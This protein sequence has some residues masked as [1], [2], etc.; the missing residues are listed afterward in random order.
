LSIASNPTAPMMLKKISTSNSLLAMPRAV[1]AAGG[2]SVLVIAMRSIEPP[3]A[4]ANERCSTVDLSCKNISTGAKNRM[5]E[6]IEPSTSA[7]P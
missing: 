7:A 6:K 1:P 3:T 2:C 4:K 5:A